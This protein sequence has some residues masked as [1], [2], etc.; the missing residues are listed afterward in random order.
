MKK[1]LQQGLNK[2]QKFGNLILD[3]TRLLLNKNVVT[4]K[5]SNLVTKAGNAIK[6]AGKKI[7]QGI[8]ALQK[9][10][11][12]GLLKDLMGRIFSMAVTAGKAVAGIP[13]VGPVLAVAAIAAAIGGGMALYNKFKSQPGDDVMSEGGYGKRTLFGPE[14]AIRLNDKDTVV[15][16][17]DLFGKSKTSKNTANTDNSALVAEMQAI[18]SILQ[19]ILTKEGAVMIDGNKVG[20]TLALASYKTQ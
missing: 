5:L 11:I 17:T 9:K 16:G 10:G 3:K 8:N 12:L 15:A 19:Q 1:S 18:K 6:A 7:Q 13:I 4:Q 20:S 14:G 2:L